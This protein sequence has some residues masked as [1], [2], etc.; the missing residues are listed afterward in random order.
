M[1]G[2]GNRT[3]PPPST[4]LSHQHRTTRLG[5]TDSNTAY[6]NPDA[7][8]GSGTTS[9]PGYGNKRSTTTPTPPAHS[10]STGTTTGTSTSTSTAP[11]TNATRLGSGCTAGAGYGN[12]TAGESE[13]GGLG[14]VV[15]R[16]GEVVGSAGEG[17]G[18]RL[19]DRDG[20]VC[21]G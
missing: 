18:R 15:V 10:P 5:L 19:R 6:H 13:R 16:V 20:E 14:G 4:A 12:K 7:R 2:Y 3:A 9:G 17:V 11:Y 1:T 8:H 21:V